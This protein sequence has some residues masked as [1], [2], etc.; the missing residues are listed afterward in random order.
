[1]SGMKD[2]AVVVSG[3][4]F[5]A[6]GCVFSGNSARYSGGAVRVSGGLATLEACVL[7]AN[8]A[9]VN[10]GGV[11][12]SGGSMVMT[13]GTLLTGNSAAYG[14]SAFREA[15]PGDES[16]LVYAT[17]APDGRW[18]LRT[19]AAECAEGETCFF[20]HWPQL[21]ARAASVQIIVA[22][23]L[24]ED[25]PYACAPGLFGRSGAPANEQS[26]PACSGLC[27]AGY[28]CGSATVAPLIC[29]SGHY[30][31]AGSA[32]V[33]P[34]AAGSYHSSTGRQSQADCNSCP[35]G[36]SC[37]S[38][39]TLAQEC[40]P[41]SFSATPG[42]AQCPL[43]P[44]GSYQTA[45]NATACAACEP[46]QWCAPGSVQGAPCEGGRYANAS[47]LHSPGQCVDV[48]PGYWAPLGSAVPEA[49]SS[50]FFCPGRAQDALYSGA[51]PIIVPTGGI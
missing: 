45:S 10:G 33:T 15:R 1:M 11:Y 7:T 12:V 3:G 21:A 24:E 5:R 46:G 37:R 27:P 18:I 4:T 25:F 6:V 35:P 14:A 42:A 9:I 39:A 31:P 40:S 20:Q 38:G 8:S 16:N 2:S 22:G 13:G 36:S 43:C 34:C 30:C 28:S 51:R 48:L 47:G 44:G 17:P 26:G 19:G 49:C 41:G 50:G 32:I 23:S 29:A